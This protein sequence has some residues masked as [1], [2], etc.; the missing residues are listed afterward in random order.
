MLI[1]LCLFISE[2]IPFLPTQEKGILSIALKQSKKFIGYFVN[3]RPKIDPNPTI[4][5]QMDPGLGGNIP[6]P[7]GIAGMG[8]RT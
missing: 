2:V 8:I 1:L 5:Q 3:P 6:G 4:I 7:G